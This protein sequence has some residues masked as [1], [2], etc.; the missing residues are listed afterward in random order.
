MEAI[1]VDPRKTPPS[2]MERGMKDVKL[3]FAI[4]H[5]MP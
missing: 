4:N 5:T 1:I 3:I 2:E